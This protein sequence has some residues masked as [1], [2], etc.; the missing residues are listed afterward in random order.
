M[1]P[2]DYGVTVERK[3][4]E[5]KCHFL[6]TTSRLYAISLIYHVA[7]NPNTWLAELLLSR[8]PQ[9]KVTIFP[10]SLSYSLEEVT[11]HGLNLRTR[12]LCSPPQK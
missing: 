6:Y 4:T 5:A 8:C 11:K 1:F 12:E 2:D 10:V 3:I 7:A 9:C